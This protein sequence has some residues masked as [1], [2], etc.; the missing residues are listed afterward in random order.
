MQRDYKFSSVIILQFISVII[1]FLIAKLFGTSPNDLESMGTS[2]S[3]IISNILTTIVV[4]TFQFMIAR[5]LV[6]NRMGTVGEYMDGINYLNLKV[7]GVCFLISLLPNLAWI[8]LGFS[9]VTTIAAGFMIN[10]SFDAVSAAVGLVLLILIGQI[11]YSA[12]TN[13]RFLL[14]A[15][16]PELSFA[17]LFKGTFKVGKD[18]F[19]KT[20]K[21]YAKWLILPVL[22]FIALI[23]PLGTYANGIFSFFLMYIL[24]LA[25]AIYAVLATT[26]VLGELSNHYLDYKNDYN[27]AYEKTIYEA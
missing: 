3:G 23:V 21:T 12:F 17:D 13:Y 4:I 25:F 26:F 18:L 15:D 20:L 10:N 5:G 22:V 7:I 6:Y 9:L 2:F 19:G 11:V 14:A 24:I 16:R 27:K 1:V 8:F